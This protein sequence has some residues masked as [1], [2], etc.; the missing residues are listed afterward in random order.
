MKRKWLYKFLSPNRQIVPYLVLLGTLVLTAIAT[1]YAESTARSQDQLQFNASVQQTENLIRDRVKTYIALLRAGSGLF[2]SHDTVDREEFRAY[3]EQ[4]KLRGEY[5]GIQGIGFTI[6]VRPSEKDQLIARMKTEGIPN[7]AINPD[8]PRPEYHTII[9]LEPLD[10]RNQAAIGFDMFT[11]PVRRRAMEHAR[12]GGVPVASGKVK[13]RQEIDAKKQAGFLIYFPIYRGNS[14]PPTVT[15][16][17]QKLLGFIYS[18]FRI[19]DFMQGLFGSHP[20]A[21][22]D[23]GIYDG[24]AITPSSVLYDSNSSRLLGFKPQFERRKMISIAGQTWTI[25]YT[26]RPELDFNS[27]RL[28]APYIALVGSFVGIIL[29][30]L[31]RSQINARYIAEKTATELTKSE[32]ALRDSEAWFRT[33]IETTFDGII[34]HENGIILDANQGA[35]IM[36]DY[37]WGQMMGSSF[38][39]LVT[40]ASQNLILQNIKNNREAPLEVIGFRKNGTIFDVEIIGRSQIYKGRQVQVT[41]LR[42]ITNRKQ[43]EAQLRTRAEELTEANR[44]KDE[45]LATL[46]HEL[47]T[48]LNAILGWTQLLISRDLDKETFNRATETINRNTRALSQLIED[49]LD[50]SRI[51][52]GKLNFSPNPTALIP[53]IETAIETVRSAAQTKNITIDISFESDIGM[54]IADS[55]RLQ[56]VMWNLLTN[57]IKFSSEGGQIQVRVYKYQ[58]QNYLETDRNSETIDYA[59]IQVSDTGQG[60]SKDFLPFVFERFRQ[61]DGSITRKQGGLGLGLTIVHHLV[62]LHGGTVTVD[63]PGLGKGT[64]FTLKLPLMTSEMLKDYQHLQGGIGDNDLIFDSCLKL[65]GVKILVVDDQVDARDLVAHILQNCGSEVV[66]VGS[67]EEALNIFKA[68]SALSPFHILI[69]DIGLSGGDGYSLL[70]QIRLLPPEEGGQIPA[71]AL[72]TYAKDEDRQAAFSAGFYAHL[73]KPVEPHELLFTIANLIRIIG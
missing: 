38:L 69:S 19:G 68:N 25:I 3:M 33:L 57:A 49:L 56:Q 11:E 7:F 12:D 9:Y 26:S 51:I 36:F 4:L 34:I 52:S 46:S 31:M 60:I 18:P 42:D 67:A 21:F 55:N 53:V 27:Q 43:L 16:R 50:V 40:P 61:A 72:T 14:T 6:R 30:G 58:D 24:L 20:D 37:P 32:K 23:F 5:P 63:S 22:V 28:M 35:Y 1:Y 17:R 65:K 10:E 62:E 48:P 13:L 29:F 54:I 70:R 47:R 2:A 64:V 73:A 15:E 66:T 59:E 41:A 45:F 39:D 44:L 71:L 8:Y